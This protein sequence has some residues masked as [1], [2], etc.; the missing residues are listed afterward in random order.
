LYGFDAE[1]GVPSSEQ[2]QQRMHPE[3]RD[4]VVAVFNRAVAQRTDYEVEF[5]MLLPDGAI[6]YAHGVG[7]P[8]FNSAGDLVEYVGTVMDVSDRRRSE[9]ERERL[10]QA[11]ADLTHISRVTTMGELTAS[12]AHE[13]TQPIAAALTNAN[14]CRR[15]LTRDLPDLDEARQAALRVA[16]DLGRASDIISR[17][18]LLFKKSAPKRE[19]VDVNEVIRDMIVLLSDAA[20]RF[21][22]SIRPDVADALP[23]V[24]ADRVQLQQ[25]LMNLMLN[26]IDAMRDMNGAGELTVK[27]QRGGDGELLISVSDTGVGLPLERAD[28]IFN[29]FFSTKPHGTG[30]G[31]PISRSIVEAHGGRLWA[32]PNSGR[33]ATFQFT[34]PSDVEGHQ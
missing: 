1:K 7:H 31:L 15:W 2:F 14:A 19:L 29:A 20:N 11:E 17:I 6:R 12:L 26:G 24:M 3:D 33:G 34:L 9:Q 32:A 16:K 10:R 4:R 27:S 30:M 5:R 22:I 28:Q 21:S 13:I 25:V 8:V 18:R 23:K